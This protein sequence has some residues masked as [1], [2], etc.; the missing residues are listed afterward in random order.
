MNWFHRLGR[1]VLGTELLQLRSEAKVQGWLWIA[2][3]LATVVSLGLHANQRVEN[4]ETG[5]QLVELARRLDEMEASRQKR[6]SDM[7][8][9][10]CLTRFVKDLPSRVERTDQ[11]TDEEVRTWAKL[12][13]RERWV[14]IPEWLRLMLPR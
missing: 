2:N 10:I 12:V 4:R 9:Y 5:Y 6:E 8:E 11:L 3:Y 7:A 1:R 13:T 14:E